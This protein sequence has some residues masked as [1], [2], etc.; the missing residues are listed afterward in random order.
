MGKDVY[1]TKGLK[2]KTTSPLAKKFPFDH[3]HLD[4]FPRFNCGRQNLT[5]PISSFL[6][7]VTHY[8]SSL[9]PGWPLC[10][11]KLRD[12]WRQ[13]EQTV[14]VRD[15]A[16]DDIALNQGWV[17]THVEAAS[18]SGNERQC[19]AWLLTQ[20]I[21]R[22]VTQESLVHAIGW[23]KVMPGCITDDTWRLSMLGWWLHKK[24]KLTEIA[25]LMQPLSVS[26]CIMT[27]MLFHLAA[28]SGDRSIQT[29]WLTKV[30]KLYSLYYISWS[31]TNYL[32]FMLILLFTPISLS[33]NT[34]LMINTCILKY[35]PFTRK[36]INSNTKRFTD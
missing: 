6:T 32:C 11:R 29:T 17:V 5:T 36:R 14:W 30:V 23:S 26:E 15:Q 12:T 8:T 21:K 22:C 28:G 1:Y 19:D 9:W 10:Q 33:I 34:Y 18:Y 3:K 35:V 27:V 31:W 13:E 16:V 20:L 7:T 2:H 25:L 4:L 24:C